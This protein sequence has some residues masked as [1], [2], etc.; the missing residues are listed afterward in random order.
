M[1]E[2]FIMGEVSEIGLKLPGSVL[3]PDLN[4]GTMSDH[5]NEDERTPEIETEKT[6]SV[7]SSLARFIQ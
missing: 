5:L 4:M 6:L 7:A 1:F 2:D 3:S